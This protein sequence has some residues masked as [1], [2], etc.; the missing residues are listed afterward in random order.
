MRQPM[1]EPAVPFVWQGQG[2]RGFKPFEVREGSSG[3]LESSPAE[4][5]DVAYA[6][7][8][9]RSVPLT[10]RSGEPRRLRILGQYK[11]SLILLEGPDGL[12]LV[13]QH[14]AH[15]RVLYERLRQAAARRWS[16]RVRQRTR[17]VSRSP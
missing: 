5:A 16:D 2:R 8:T 1:S 3:D 12:F 7:L 14:A 4:L 11:G 13:D 15:E 17:R 6:P 9:P 10:G